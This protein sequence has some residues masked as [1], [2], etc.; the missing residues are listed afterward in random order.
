MTPYRFATQGT[1]LRGW[2]FV[3]SYKSAQR[4]RKVRAVGSAVQY[5]LITY[6]A[7]I[8]DVAIQGIDEMFNYWKNTQLF[9]DNNKFS[10]NLTKCYT[11]ANQRYDYITSLVK[12]KAFFSDLCD[13]GQEFAHPYVYQ[14]YEGYKNLYKGKCKRYNLI[15]HA[16]TNFTIANAVGFRTRDLLLDA[17]QQKVAIKG[18]EKFAMQE[19]IQCLADIISDFGAWLDDEGCSELKRI[20]D[21]IAKALQPSQILKAA[22]LGAMKYHPEM[23]EEFKAQTSLIFHN[24]V[25]E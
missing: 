23:A 2:N 8:A 15:A 1:G 4:E 9:K 20:T 14:L 7:L 11:L 22:G 19:E 24:I 17:E 5:A 3:Q 13:A 10:S 25:W 6:V 21:S 12:D 16:A 18:A